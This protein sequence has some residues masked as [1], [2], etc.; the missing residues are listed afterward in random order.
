M[1]DTL[2]PVR[3]VAT[4]ALPSV[5]VDHIDVT[6]H[7][8]ADAQHGLLQ[9]IARRGRRDTRAI[10]AVKDVSFIARQGEAIGVI[11]HN[12]SGKSTLLKAISGLVPL[13]RGRVY[14]SS[15]PVLLGVS[16]A[17]RPELSGRRNIVLGATAR[18]LN[19]S[20]IEDKADAVIEF[21]GLRDFIDLPL[22]TYSSGMRSRLQF[23]IATVTTPEILIVD[24]AL[25]TGDAD[26]KERSDERI[27]SMLSGAGT[28]FLATH[29]MSSVTDICNRVI[30]L[31]H[32]DLIAIGDPEPIT[33]AYREHNERVKAYRARYG[34]G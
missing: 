9:R 10:P 1:S 26:F 27:R 23:S 15:T 30:W 12:G 31:D 16:A 33:E 28:V 18:G 2:A 20:E 6:Y 29:V 3:H 17:L 34:Q 32:G 5:V 8:N 13:S 11:G 14:T 22:R 25:A 19:R 24:E 4:D 21:S 7:I